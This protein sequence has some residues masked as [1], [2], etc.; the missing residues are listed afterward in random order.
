MI[1]NSQHIKGLGL[2]GSSPSFITIDIWVLFSAP[3]LVRMHCLQ[4]LV[5]LRQAN[6]LSRNSESSLW[7]NYVEFEYL[8][9]TK[10]KLLFLSQINYYKNLSFSEKN[11]TILQLLNINIF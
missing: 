7:Y 3:I 5:V 1:K 11:K 4:V 8:P 10:F 9:T 2:L 6:I